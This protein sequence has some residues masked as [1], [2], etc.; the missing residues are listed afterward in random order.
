MSTARHR[1]HRVLRWY[2][3]TH[4]LITALIGKF[5][6]IF[7][8]SYLSQKT[9]LIEYLM[10]HEK[11]TPTVKREACNFNVRNIQKVAGHSRYRISSILRQS[12]VI[13]DVKLVV[14]AGSG[15]ALE[16]YSEVTWFESRPGM[17]HILTVVS[18]SLQVTGGTTATY[19]D[20]LIYRTLM[21][22]TS[23]DST[24]CNTASGR[25]YIH[26]ITGERINSR[27]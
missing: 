3:V 21:S 15:I 27:S 1:Q 5:R 4:L 11:L 16:L 10:D 6:N 19:L 26:E 8:H 13:I 20:I 17:P 12:D 23:L 24:L 18:S 22:T 7:Q 9:R 2:S 14:L 25:Q